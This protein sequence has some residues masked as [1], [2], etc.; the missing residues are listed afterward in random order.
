M[1]LL[2]IFLTIFVSVDAARILGLCV[3]PAKSHGQMTNTILLELARRGHEVFAITNTPIGKNLT[4]FTEIE[5]TPAYDFWPVGKKT[6]SPQIKV[7]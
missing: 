5:V 2:A 3:F 4:N 7:E 6:T 1:Q